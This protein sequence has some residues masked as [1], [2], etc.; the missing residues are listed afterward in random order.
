[1]KTDFV[2]VLT[3]FII[4]LAAVVIVAVLFD[5]N[6]KPALRKDVS[7]WETLPYDFK[8]D[9]CVKNTN[10]NLPVPKTER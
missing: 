7:S 3:V 5:K 6:G 2:L 10:S 4:C 8:V 9:W 1:M